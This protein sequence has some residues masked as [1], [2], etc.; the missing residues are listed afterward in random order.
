M[1]TLRPIGVLVLFGSCAK[2]VGC[3]GTERPS[4]N[5]EVDTLPGCKCILSGDHQG[6]GSW[7]RG[8]REVRPRFNWVLVVVCLLRESDLVNA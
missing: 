4:D 6:V 5:Q 8:W 7:G 3:D 2:T 1:G